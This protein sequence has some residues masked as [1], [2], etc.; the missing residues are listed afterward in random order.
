[1]A[2]LGGYEGVRQASLPGLPDLP[3]WPIR[4]N[5][6]GLCP[7]FLH[8]T[9]ADGGVSSHPAPAVRSCLYPTAGCSPSVFASAPAK[10]VKR[11]GR[12]HP[13][14]G[15]PG[16][17]GSCCGDGDRTTPS[18]EEGRLENLLFPFCSVRPVVKNFKKRAV[19]FFSG[20]QEGEDGSARDPVSTLP[21]PS[22][23]ASGQQGPVRGRDAFSRAPCPALEP[24]ECRTI[25]SDSTSGRTAFRV[26]PLCST[27]AAPPRVRRWLPCSRLYGLWG[28][29]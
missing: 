7:T 19:S 28:P 9:K 2:D 23:F 3:G 1:M 17:S 4:W 8:R 15:R 10:L 5:G 29:G 25:H 16:A 18:P 20:S 21:S 13:W 26:G 12:R 14:D 24:G 27:F 6:G 22:P 11:Q